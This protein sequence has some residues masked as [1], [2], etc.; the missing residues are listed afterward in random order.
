MQSPLRVVCFLALA[1]C[2]RSSAQPPV[3]LISVDTLRADYLS[4]YGSK[5]RPTSNIDAL[6]KGGTLFAQADAQAPLT[7]PSHVSML[8]S[9]YPFVNGIRDN[10]QKLSGKEITLAQVLRARGYRTG[11]FVGGFVLDRQ[12][13]L[14]K[15]F[16]IYDSPFRPP[17]DREADS[18]DLKRLGEDV[19]DSAFR[20]IEKQAGAPFFLFLHLFDLHTPDNLPQ[21][22]RARFP[23]PRYQA[24]LGYVDMVLG[25]FFDFLKKR[26]LYEKTL[27]RLH[28]G[29][30]G[31]PRR[32]WRE[33]PWILHLPEHPPR[34]V[35]YPLAERDGALSGEIGGRGQ[36]DDD[37]ADNCRGGRR[38]AARQ[39]QGKSL[40]GQLTGKGPRT[41]EEIYSESLYAWNHFGTSG[42]FSLRKGRYKYIHAPQPE[43]YDLAKTPRR[44]PIYTLSGDPWRKAI[45][46]G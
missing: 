35:D 42:L 45:S 31:K 39:F 7:L 23:G 10:G 32:S 28:C 12:F 27:D 13:G 14:D 24:E 20:W 29:S 33:L 16:D 5:G 25:N 6:T 3:I 17:V 36:S 18:A 19:V 26:G 37:C 38:S 43:F 44:K 11:A 8:T 2:A 41:L 34:A 22:M 40:T 15:G 46:R 30:R 9:T 21:A 1:V 4:C